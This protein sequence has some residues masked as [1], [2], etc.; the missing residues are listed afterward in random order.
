[1]M[2]TKRLFEGK[3][4]RERVCVCVCRSARGS[5]LYTL[6]SAQ[7]SEEAWTLGGGYQPSFKASSC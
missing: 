1:M 7:P 5:V 6:C 3:Q 2:R 4:N